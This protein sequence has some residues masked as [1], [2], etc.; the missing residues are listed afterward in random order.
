V[1]DKLRREHLNIST[2]SRNYRSRQKFPLA[3]ARKPVPPRPVPTR[4]RHAVRAG[5]GG[6][7]PSEALFALATPLNPCLRL[8]NGHP[9]SR[10]LEARFPNIRDR[11]PVTNPRNVR[12]RT[13]PPR[14]LI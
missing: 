5:A 8:S 3:T 1:A 14:E 9:P 7:R 4:F 13:S 2:T 6:P 11:M 12:P 10:Q